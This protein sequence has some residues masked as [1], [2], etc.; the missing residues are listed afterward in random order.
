MAGNNST[1]PIALET[2]AQDLTAPVRRGVASHPACP[3][4]ALEMLAQDRDWA[5]RLGVAGNLSTPP[6][7]L[8]RLL[9]DPALAKVVADNPSLPAELERCGS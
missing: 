8:G 3:S 6:D 7:V 2:L 1:P 9:Q 5:V 4:G